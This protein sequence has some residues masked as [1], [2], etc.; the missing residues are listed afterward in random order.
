MRIAHAFL[1]LACCVQVGAATAQAQ[2]VIPVPA[3]RQ[4][5]GLGSEAADALLAKLEEMQ[6][7]LT[8]GRFQSF[9]LMAGSIASYDQANISPRAVFLAIPFSKVWN[10]ERV[11]GTNPLRSPYRLAYAPNGLGK[12]YWDIEVALDSNGDVASVAMMFRPPAPF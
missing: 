11:A 9:E 2:T 8:S 3:K 1:C 4:L 10:I 12:P 6:R 5:T 7:R